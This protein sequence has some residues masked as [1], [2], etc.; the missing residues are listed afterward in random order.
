MYAQSSHEIKHEIINPMMG[1]I[2]PA[3][4]NQHDERT[5]LSD[6]MLAHLLTI[7]DNFEEEDYIET[8]SQAGD[9]LVS[10]KSQL[11]KAQSDLRTALQNHL[12]PYTL[13]Y[14]ISLN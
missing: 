13:D 11:A 1:I 10:I 6:R 4:Q 12:T 8:C 7:L 14:R 3:L 5:S 2:L 9:S